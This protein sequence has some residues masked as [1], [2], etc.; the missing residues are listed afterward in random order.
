[1]VPKCPKTPGHV[2]FS[3]RQKFWYNRHVR[4]FLINAYNRKKIQ[5]NKVRMICYYTNECIRQDCTH[6]HPTK[7]EP[8]NLPFL[9][10]ITEFF[11]NQRTAGTLKK[12]IVASIA[13]WENQ[14]R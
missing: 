5:D 13:Y 4:T 3:D 6:W 9:K 14:A 10:M 11:K 2:H 7:D 1:M 8:V 12:I